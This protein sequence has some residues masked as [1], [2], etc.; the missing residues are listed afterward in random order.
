MSFHVHQINRRFDHE[1]F[2]DVVERNEDTQKL[3]LGCGVCEDQGSIRW[4]C[5]ISA[6]ILINFD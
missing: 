4:K 3:F 1:F 5:T 2:V 6:S